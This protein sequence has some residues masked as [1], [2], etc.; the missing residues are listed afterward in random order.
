[1]VQEMQVLVLNYQ[2]E[3][4]T[5]KVAHERM[6]E[7]LSTELQLMRMRLEE[8]RASAQSMAAHM[9]QLEEEL[10][11]CMLNQRRGPLA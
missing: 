11:T 9:N 7:R 3:V 4:I 6:E 2:E 1:M 10:G 8:Q 5:T